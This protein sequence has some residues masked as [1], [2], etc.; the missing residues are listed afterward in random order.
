M[1]RFH[2]LPLVPRACLQANLKCSRCHS[3]LRALPHSSFGELGHVSVEDFGDWGK[4]SVDWDAAQGSP[5]PG[6]PLESRRPRDR[7][8]PS[9]ARPFRLLQPTSRSG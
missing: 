7:E 2:L 6:F 4:P 5:S 1:G 3:A 9:P 8:Q